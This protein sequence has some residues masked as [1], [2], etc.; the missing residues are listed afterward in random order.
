[1]ESPTWV[2]TWTRSRAYRNSLCGQ[3]PVAYMITTRLPRLNPTSCR[4]PFWFL[5]PCC[6]CIIARDCFQRTD[7]QL[8]SSCTHVRRAAPKSTG[9]F[10]GTAPTFR[11]TH[12]SVH[13][14]RQRGRIGSAAQV[15]PYIEHTGRDCIGRNPVSSGY[16]QYPYLPNK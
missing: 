15:L 2:M 12:H 10:Q 11:P 3:C 7:S 13:S 8:T 4:N 9:P 6:K 14:D 5:V 16:H 1:M